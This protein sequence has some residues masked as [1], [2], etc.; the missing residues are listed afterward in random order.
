MPN[1]SLLGVLEVVWWHRFSS[2]APILLGN[3]GQ[4]GMWQ[5]TCCMSACDKVSYHPHHPTPSICLTNPRQFFNVFHPQPSVVVT[6]FTLWLRPGALTSPTLGCCSVPIRE[7]ACR[8]THEDVLQKN[9]E[10][11]ESFDKNA[12]QWSMSMKVLC[13]WSSNMSFSLRGFTYNSANNSLWLPLDVPALSLSWRH[14]A[15]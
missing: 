9:W 10:S 14:R 8:N 13:V 4:P 2:W 6:G 15:L 3:L 11:S 7:L 12:Y 1:F 5:Q